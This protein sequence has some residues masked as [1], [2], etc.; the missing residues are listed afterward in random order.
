M[1]LVLS[2]RTLQTGTANTTVSFTLSGSVTG[3][4]SF[5][6]VGNGNTTYYGSTDVSGNW[7]VG[8]GTYSTTGPTLTRTTILAS[9]NAGSA[10]TFSGTVTVFVTYPA[11]KSA[12]T[13]AA[14]TSGR[15]TY[16][17]TNGLLT[18]SASLVFDGTTLSVGGQGTLA[19]STFTAN[20]GIA[21]K[22]AA[23]SGINP[24]L[25]LY[26]GNASTDLKTW[27]LGGLTSGALSIETVN[28]AYTVSS[29]VMT[30]TN[31]GNVGIGT[32]SPKSDIG[33]S[34]HLFN[35]ASTGTVASNVYLL[36][37]SSTRNAVVEVSGSATSTNAFNFSDTPG[38]AVAGIASTVSDQNLFFRTGGTTE[39][40]RIDSSGNVGIG[41]SSPT[42][43]LQVAGNARLG[44]SAWL[45]FPD[46]AGALLRF[47]NGEFIATT[48]QQLQLCADNSDGTIAFCTTST[49]SASN[50]RARIDSSGNV[51]IGTSSPSTFS[52][53]GGKTLVVASSTTLSGQATY[54]GYGQQI[55]GAINVYQD[56]TNSYIR[57]V[58]F[59]AF[60][61]GG[62]G[63]AGSQF[64]FL[65]QV[66][67]G[68][69]LAE[70]MRI[71]SSGNVGIGATANASAILD[72]QSTTKGVRMPNMTTTQKN[73]I[74]SPAAG[75]MVFDTTLSKLCVYSGTAWQTVTS[76]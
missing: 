51:G 75:L 16:A 66:V 37:E 68:G 48:G 58:D 38:T 15:V 35:S 62:S 70:R 74:S 22:T 36:V 23:A 42:Q 59:C 21:A 45:G 3:Y 56:N 4:Q 49:G 25:Q 61:D 76:I 20:T 46:S 43:K 24:Y 44:T 65:N 50:E 26:N 72:A 10:V 71:D 29:G 27:R 67:G 41:T 31:A 55:A 28:D 1:A 2:D 53:T 69:A 19:N 32:S 18:D 7:E 33:L 63:G 30:F 54:S 52:G 64:R 9:S 8:L 6:V 5:A 57:N 60:G 73:A 13:N 11:E 34:L 47:S 39:R 14:L 40:M 17:T 12:N